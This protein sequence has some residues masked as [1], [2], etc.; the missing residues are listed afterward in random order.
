ME[1]W[2][3]PQEW[4]ESLDAQTRAKAD[5]LIA[6][7][8]RF[9][10]DDP[11][12]WVSS[13]MREDIPQVARFLF[14]HEVRTKLIGN[15]GSRKS[16]D[17][18]SKRHPDEIMAA[19]NDAR[20]RLIKSGVSADDLDRVAHAAACESV[21]DFISL[22]DGLEE[23]EIDDLEDAPRWVVA[24]VAGPIGESKLTGRCLDG[25]HES[26]ITLYPTDS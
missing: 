26:I 16:A 18:D 13:E 2:V 19:G 20:N 6:I 10:A 12:S 25:L 15:F 8:E 3:P 7:L 21:F 11:A 14:L 4:L 17:T 9:G 5:R 22:L 23:S 1:R 24:E